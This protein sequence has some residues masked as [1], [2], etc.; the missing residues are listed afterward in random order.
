MNR[1]VIF[2][3]REFSFASEDD[4]PDFGPMTDLRG[5]FEIRTGILNTA[6]RLIRE[7]G[8]EAVAYFVPEELRGVVAER[9]SCRVN[10]LPDDEL[11]FLLVN[12]RWSY[13]AAKFNLNT[14]QAVV[15]KAGGAVIAAD[16]KREDA[17]EFLSRGVLGDSV[18]R[19]EY[20]GR[21][22][23]RRPWE[24]I[25]LLDKVLLTD[26]LSHPL[27]QQAGESGV[28]SRELPEGV[29]AFGEEALA[30]D[31]GARVYP[32]VTF[33]LEGGPILIDKGAT[34]RTG[35]IIR[36]PVYVG[37]GSTILERS[38][39]KGNTV[40]GP[41]CKV[42]GEV[43]GTIFQGYSNKAH[44]GH[45]G[46]SYVGEWVNFGAGT[47]N[48]N[49]LNTYGEV[50]VQLRPGGERERTGMAYLGAIIGDHVKFG[51]NTKIM[52]GTVVGTGAMIATTPAP[53]GSVESFL[54][55]T[56]KDVNA[57]LWGKFI[58]VAETVM[59][60]RGIELTEAMRG[61]LKVLH[62]KITGL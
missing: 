27:I 25:G 58:Q 14:G 61:R 55:L 5:V 12:G 47:T 46:D 16:L 2:D 29:I 37:Y 54:W 36:G 44:A 45:L 50:R 22:L 52:T 19:L 57:F 30:I 7:W 48:S 33:D 18:E 32:G 13:P 15:E 35:A 1:M 42:A 43:G 3:D 49:L 20:E 56:D 24:V 59:G 11:S 6:E 21:L 4:R 9:A 53:P 38:L 10:S 62:E 41:V 31:G 39:I 8:E 40:V 34:I 23:I 28:E 51:I 60:R 17:E 26:L